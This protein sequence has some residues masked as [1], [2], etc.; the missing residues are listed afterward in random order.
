MWYLA[1]FDSYNTVL[2]QCLLK[3]RLL[4]N[5]TRQYNTQMLKTMEKY[6]SYLIE[7]IG[8]QVNGVFK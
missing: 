5:K 2:L 8:C 4:F 3:K 7:N 6:K 1:L